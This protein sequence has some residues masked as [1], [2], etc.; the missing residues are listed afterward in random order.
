MGELLINP[1]TNEKTISTLEIAEMIEVPHSNLLKML[2]G[3]KDRKGY[4][5]ILNEGQMS[6]VD[7]F[8]KSSYLDSKGEER[9]CY[10]VTK[11]GCDFLAN[12]FTGEKGIIFSARYVKRFSEMEKQLK[13]KA[14]P[15]SYRDAV[16]QLLE[17]LDRE[18]ELRA[19][20]YTSKDWFSIKRVA[21]LNGVSC[22]IFDW[23][24]LKSVGEQ[25][26]YP[27]KKIFD[28]NYGEVNTYHRL[29]W[30]A[31]YPKYEL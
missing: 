4:I 5:Q 24:I 14:L 27:V 13:E 22:K 12:K 31:A 1:I 8:V 26:G 9:P 17:S 2:D 29:V 11:L 3:R 6:V 23:R 19:Q 30:E 10:N 15:M 28:A 25:M 21:A 20:L 18:E 16:A 7:Y